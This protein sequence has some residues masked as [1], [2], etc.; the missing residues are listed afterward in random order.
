MKGTEASLLAVGGIA[1]LFCAWIALKGMLATPEKLLEMA[2]KIGTKNP[3][4]ARVLCWPDLSRSYW[5]V[6]D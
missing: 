3:L 5:A 2:D 4:L 6:S 1:C